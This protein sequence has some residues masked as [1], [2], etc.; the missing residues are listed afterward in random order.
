MNISGS[1]Q[2]EAVIGEKMI[3]EAGGSPN[4]AV[5]I[6]PQPFTETVFN[7][8]EVSRLGVSV[9]GLVHTLNQTLLENLRNN[10]ATKI[11]R[12]IKD[13][14]PFLTQEQFDEMC[15]AYDFSGV[16]TAS[17]SGDE[18]RTALQ[19][20]QFKLARKELKRLLRSGVFEF[21]EFD[22]SFGTVVTVAKAD[23]DPEAGQITQEVFE[24]YVEA[25]IDGE[26]EPWAGEPEFETSETGQEVPANAAAIRALILQEAE[27]E[28]AR[29]QDKAAK[30]SNNLKIKMA[31]PAA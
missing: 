5:F 28:Y 23:E 14:K 31:S 18:G 8:D 21:P 17:T 26:E 29:T 15:R 22:I 10:A 19:R 3:V 20:I 6:F 9:K 16:R 27:E 1:R 2:K 24:T 7:L 13:N 25:L 12:L 11:K 4:D 30:V